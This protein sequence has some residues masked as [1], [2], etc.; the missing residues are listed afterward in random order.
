MDQ[1]LID[2]VAKA[3]QAERIVLVFGL[4]DPLGSIAAIVLD[5]IQHFNDLLVGTTV[6]QPQ[7]AATPA[8]TDA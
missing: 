7:S 5:L 8:A 4:L 2:P 1:N 3:H 6:Q